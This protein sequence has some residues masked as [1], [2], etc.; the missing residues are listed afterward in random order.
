[1]RFAPVAPLHLYKKLEA[2]GVLGNYHLM[3]ASEVLKDPEGQRDFWQSRSGDFI[4][5]DN[6]VIELGYSLPAEDIYT[7]AK[8]VGAQVII[9]PDVIGDANQTLELS[10]NGMHEIQSQTADPLNFLGV[11]QGKDLFEAVWCAKRFKDLGV[12]MLSVPRHFGDSLG[13]RQQL[14]TIIRE[15]TGLPIH[16][17]GFSERMADD[18][19]TAILPGV[20]GIDSALPLWLGLDPRREYFPAQPPIRADYG[21]RPIKY[22]TMDTDDM[23]VVTSN[24][25]KVQM[26]LN[27]AR[28]VHTVEMPSVP[29]ETLQHR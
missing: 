8:I 5:M 14:V 26:W 19:K 10:A 12:S 3:I 24:T 20:T 29:E 6:G 7:A 2:Q 4:M 1:M 23:F 18:I 11:V 13:S 16:L 22:W 17:L 28:G 25:R 21:R 15:A 9:L 27:V